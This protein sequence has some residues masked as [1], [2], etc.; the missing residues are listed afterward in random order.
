MSIWIQ[1]AGFLTS[2]QDAG[3]FGYEKFGVPCSGPMDRFALHAAN[4]LVGNS[5]FAAGLEFGISDVSLV[6][7]ESCLIAVTGAGYSLMIDGRPMPLWM[8]ILAR[9][10]TRLSLRK[11][12][13][14][15]W[16]YLAVSGGIATPAVMGSRATYLRGK[17]GGLHGT[18]LQD[19]D[20]LPLCPQPG[21]FLGMAGKSLPSGCRP[22]YSATPTL[23]VIP[24]PQD[25]YFTATGIDTFY[26]NTYQISPTS[27]R[28]GFRLEGPKIEHTQGADI[29]SDGMAFGSV[30]VPASGQPIVMMS[31]HPTTGGYTKIATVVSADLPV[32]AQCMPGESQVRFQRTTVEQAQA[33]YRLQIYDLEH[34]CQEKEEESL[35]YIE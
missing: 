9:C 32:L 24:G 22:A 6:C 15:N 27:D 3:R 25:E 2:I 33:R 14:G 5:Q 21:S 23:E 28:M 4:L 10:G 20:V 19:G 35:A 16:G 12:D 11:I 7:G 13:G 17:I 8:A 26:N 18:P 34:N 1:S 30:Q 29:L 31:E